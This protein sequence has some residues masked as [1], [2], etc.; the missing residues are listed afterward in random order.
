MHTRVSGTPTSPIVH[1]DKLKKFI[2]YARSGIVGMISRMIKR[3]IGLSAGVAA[4]VLTTIFVL[5]HILL[6]VFVCLFELGCALYQHQAFQPDFSNPT[7][8][9]GVQLNEE[10]RRLAVQHIGPR[11]IDGIASAY[12][13][14]G[15][16]V[17]D[18][19]TMLTATGH[20]WIEGPALF[21]D[22]RPDGKATEGFGFR[23]RIAYR[24]PR[25]PQIWFN[26]ETDRPPSKVR[27]ARGSILSGR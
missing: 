22:T 9:R 27:H 5:P 16:S 14:P 12:F 15:T 19:I 17:Q 10:T 26:L 7:V 3:T 24:A 21:R 1:P 8:K 25:N 20:V 11:T 18:A 13:P 2:D 4:A 6:F 23:A